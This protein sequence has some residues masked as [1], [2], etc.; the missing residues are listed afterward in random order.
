MA[1]RDQLAA[2][3]RHA[4]VGGLVSSGKDMPRLSAGRGTLEFSR[5]HTK[6]ELDGGEFDQLAV[7]S[8]RARLAAQ[9]RA[10]PARR[11]AG[12]LASPLLRDVLVAQGLERLS[13]MVAL[14]ADA[15]GEKELRDPAQWRVTARISDATMPLGGGLPP[16]EKLAGT[17]RYSAGQMRGLALAGNWLGGPVEIE[18]RRAT[19]GGGINFAI[20]GVADAAPLLRLLGQEEVAQRVSGQLPGRARRS[21]T[22]ATRLWKVSLASNLSGVESRLPAPFDKPRAR[23]VPVGAQLRVDADGIREFD[24]GSG[25]DMTMRGAVETGVTTAHFEVQGVSGELRSAGNASE[26]QLTIERLDMARA[27]GARR[28]RGLASRRTGARRDRRRPAL[29]RTQPGCAAGH[30]R[31]VGR[32]ASG[33]RSNPPHTALHQI[34]ARAN[35][36]AAMP[37]PRRV[38]RRNRA[39]RRV[40][41]RRAAAR[42]VAHRDLQRQVS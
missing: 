38:H 32:T 20:N 24:I 2:L 9:R 27:R 34:T 13:G 17:M 12:R 40:A 36:S 19:A 3:E 21:D 28:G 5:G 42:G 15:R 22:A 1:T 16:V 29:W 6:L 7:T 4:D 10:A 39:S 23:A 25:R 37:M 33:S 14:E 26:P 35:A 11:A 8:A 41:A 31:R 18:S 30:D